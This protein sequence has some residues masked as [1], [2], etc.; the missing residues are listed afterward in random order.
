MKICFGYPRIQQQVS[1]VE[2]KSR[3]VQKCTVK[4]ILQQLKDS[5]MQLQSKVNTKENTNKTLEKHCLRE[6]K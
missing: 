6:N 5:I 4:G 2:G 1:V 3:F